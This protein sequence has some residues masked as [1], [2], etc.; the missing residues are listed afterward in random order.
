MTLA[1]EKLKK[2]IKEAVENDKLTGLNQGVYTFRGKYIVDGHVR[3]APLSDFAIWDYL[4]E[5][6]LVDYKAEDA[7]SSQFGDWPI[8]KDIKWSKEVTD[9]IS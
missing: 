1:I 7:H 5:P 4:G 3:L 9:G 6:R 8:I 2:F